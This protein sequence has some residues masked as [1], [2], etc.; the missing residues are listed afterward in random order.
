MGT[1]RAQERPR[2]EKFLEK[3]KGINRVPTPS[4]LILL[5][6]EEQDA[7]L[8][9]ESTSLPEDSPA[10]L[11][12]MQENE[13]EL[14]TAVTSGRRCLQLSES[15]NRPLSLAKMLLVSSVWRTARHL[16]GYSLTWRMKG[17]RQNNLLFQLAV[18]VRGTEETEFGSY[19][20]GD[21]L[22][23][24]PD[25]LSGGEITNLRKDSN[26]LQGGSHSVSLTHY[27]TLFATPSVM[28]V[29]TDI[30]KP[31]ERSN[32]ANKGGCANLREQV[33]RLLPTVTAR[34]HKD[35]QG[36]EWSK[37]NSKGHLGREVH[38]TTENV[39]SLNPDWVEWL[40]GY[41]IGYTNLTESQELQ[42]ESK[43]E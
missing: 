16:M 35:G 4:E 33:S 32:K 14:T 13:K 26:I 28:D 2:S 39:G 43:E 21:K 15:L 7:Y 22:I 6:K 10:S 3:D 24:T 29:W 31:E 8:L 34:D 18:L 41:P 20:T 38:K 5:P 23:P 25:A 11:F 37:Q 40:M 9:D 27:I 30:R 17:T 36:T 1:P 19:A 42:Q 12:P